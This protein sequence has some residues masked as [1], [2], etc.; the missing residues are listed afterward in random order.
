MLFVGLLNFG[1]GNDA[2]A[3][4]TSTKNSNEIIVQSN[5]NQNQNRSNITNSSV[6]TPVV[7]RQ[8]RI[9]KNDSIAGLPNA[10]N[11]KLGKHYRPPYLEPDEKSDNGYEPFCIQAEINGRAERRCGYQ[12]SKGKILIKPI[13]K[14]AYV[15]S[16]GL[17]GVCPKQDGLCGYIN[18][19]GKLVIKWYQCN[20]KFSEGLALIC[21]GDTDYYKYGYINKKGEYV[22]RPQY[23]NASAF[24]N[25]IAEV[26]VQRSLNKCIN[27]KNENVE[28][29]K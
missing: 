10:A 17:A 11:P 3:A 24:K 16:E 20:D 13:F 14:I 9:S 15:F 29:L 28:C 27:K 4:L 7:D 2:D 21:V 6:S 19:K 26:T 18:K 22:I 1:C 12:N 25:G 5:F 8:T 23:S